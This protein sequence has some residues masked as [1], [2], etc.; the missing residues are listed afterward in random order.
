MERK[1]PVSKEIVEIIKGSMQQLNMSSN[2][3]ATYINQNEDLGDEFFV[4]H[5]I[6]FNT[7]EKNVWMPYQEADSLEHPHSFIFLEYRSERIENFINGKIHKCEYMFP[8]AMLYHLLKALYKEAGKE[9]NDKLMERCKVEAEEVLL[10]NQFYSISVQMKVRSQ[11]D[12]EEEYKKILSSFDRDNREYISQLV[13]AIQFLSQYD[14]EYTNEKLEKMVNNFRK[15]DPSF[16]LAYMAIS[17]EGIK[18]LQS[19]FKRDFLNEI[20]SLI[21][22]YAAIANTKDN[23]EKY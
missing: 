20:S 12:T 14:V 17:L 6:E 13:E 2:D 22:K 23:I 15:C 19:S 4:E 16:A 9:Y 7:I 5:N 1:L 11:S 10:D 18:T 3:L 21:E 8:F